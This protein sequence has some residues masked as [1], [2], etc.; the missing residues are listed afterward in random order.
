MNQSFIVTIEKH[1]EMSEHRGK[2][3]KKT[4]LILFHHEFFKF[5]FHTCSYVKHVEKMMRCDESLRIVAKNASKMNNSI[6]TH[7]KSVD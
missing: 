7:F 2:M 1:L 5:S 6:R 3:K 4:S